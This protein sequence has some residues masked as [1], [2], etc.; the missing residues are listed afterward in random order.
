MFN[1]KRVL[2]LEILNENMFA[3]LKSLIKL[4]LLDNNIK[5]IQNNAFYATAISPYVAKG[6]CPVLPNI[7]Y[8]DE[9]L[10]SNTKSFSTLD[11]L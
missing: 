9:K 2:T 8:I 10:N 3:S 6:Q 7:I 4:D 1:S 5:T 11:A